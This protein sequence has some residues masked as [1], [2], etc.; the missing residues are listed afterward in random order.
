MANN[1]KSKRSP[2]GA[3]PLVEKKQREWKLPKIHYY[4][5]LLPLLAFLIVF[6]V[7]WV[8]VSWPIN[9]VEINGQFTVWQ[10]GYIADELLW[11]KQESFFSADLEKVFSQVSA[12]PLLDVISVKKKWPDTIAIQVHEDVPMA[13]W[14]GEELLTVSG[15]LM[16]RPVFVSAH[17]LARMRGNSQY[18]DRA[19]RN[20]RR[21]HQM[22][23]T[24]GI[25]VV[26]L[27]MSDVGALKVW[28][29]NGWPVEFGRQYFEERMQRLEQL[30][31]KL[32]ADKVAAIDLRY[33]KGAAIEWHPVGELES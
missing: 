15:E 29:S 27:E 8:V 30:I 5:F 20:Y 21:L 23:Q 6:S 22:L 33:G 2:R 1:L 12:L 18:A 24:S 28:L 3:T 32:P 17:K 25:S 19:V 4:W 11:L 31:K 10:P 14:N 7:R 26:E 9:T 16:P 13:I